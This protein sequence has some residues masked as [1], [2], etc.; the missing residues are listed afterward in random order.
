MARENQ[1][2]QISLIVFVTLSLF[3]GVGFYIVYR[4]YDEAA[5]KAKSNADQATTAQG[6]VKMYDTDMATLKRLIGAAATDKAG[7]IEEAFNNEMKRYGSGYPEESRFYRPLLEKMQKTI[8]DRNAEL[9]SAQAKIPLLKADY[10]EFKANSDLQLKKFQAERDKAR[11]D[12]AAEQSKYNT[13]R[14]RKNQDALALQTSKEDLRKRLEGNVKEVSDKYTDVKKL[15]EKHVAI[16]DEQARKIKGLE[17]E[18]KVETPDGTITRV[19]QRNRTV[20]IN[21]GKADALMRQVTFSVYPSD[22]SDMSI[23]G[24]KGDIEVTRI[25]DDHMAEARILDDAISNPMVPGDK[26]NTVLWS[27]NQRRHFALAGFFDMDKDGKSDLSTILNIIR[28]NGGLV[29]CY[30]PDS[31]K[32]MNKP[33]GQITINT[34]YL[35]LGAAPNEK[36]D[37]A[38]LT[39]YSKIYDDAKQL[40]IPSMKIGEMLQRMG[41]KNLAPV[42]RYGRGA[43][44]EDFRAL[45]DEGGQRKSIGGGDSGGGD[46]F[47]ERK[48]PAKAPPSAYYRF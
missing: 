8:D 40:R 35:I 16:I 27:P 37:P 47:K 20:W 41:W 46:S 30:I 19:D 23:K 26:I 12:L 15:D 38:Q 13:E 3:L 29:D 4:Q 45:P 14:E 2:L 6:Q 7:T 44:P 24:K 32:N 1:G 11:Q 25:L 21:L 36:G 43:N 48:P 42:I 22:M 5:A 39:A 17:G 9:A 34:N 18:E 33:V 28:L 10:D 31:G